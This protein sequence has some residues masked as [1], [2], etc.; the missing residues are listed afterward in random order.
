MTYEQASA[1]GLAFAREDGTTLT[2]KDGVTHHFTAA[3]TTAVT[4]AR[5]RERLLRDFL[6]YRRGAIALG[7]EGHAR[8]PDPA[9]QGSVARRTRLAQLLAAQGIQVQRAEEAFQSGSA[10]DAGGHLH[11]PAGAASRTA[12]AQPARSRHQ[13]G[14]CVPEGT[15]PAPQGAAAG[16]DLRRHGVEPAADVRRRRRGERPGQR[17]SRPREVRR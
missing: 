7:T 6:E 15:G 14:R 13:D 11:R 16:S 4:A 5:N 9:R 8:I 3:I 10:A 1:R 2:Y 17:T 12:R